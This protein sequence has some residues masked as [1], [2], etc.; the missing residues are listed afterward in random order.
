[1][2]Y[3]VHDCAS[4]STKCIKEEMQ[5][6]KYNKEKKPISHRLKLGNYT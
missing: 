2:N 4:G 6:I 1:M 5:T 3:S